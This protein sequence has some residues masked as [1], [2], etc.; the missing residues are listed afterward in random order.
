LPVAFAVKTAGVL[1]NGR[2][3]GGTELSIVS[4]PVAAKFISTMLQMIGTVIDRGDCL[5]GFFDQLGNGLESWIH[6][7]V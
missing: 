2:S 1:E 5:T 6:A 7:Y 3:A 4:P